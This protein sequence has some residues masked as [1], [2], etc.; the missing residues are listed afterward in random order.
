MHLITVS[1]KI[2]IKKRVK[3]ATTEFLREFDKKWCSTYPP[4]VVKRYNL[5][6]YE[7]IPYLEIENKNNNFVEVFIEENATGEDLK[8]KIQTLASVS[9]LR[10]PEAYSWLDPDS[11]DL[12]SMDL[13]LNEDMMITDVGISTIVSIA[14]KKYD[15]VTQKYLETFEIPRKSKIYNQKYKSEPPLP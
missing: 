13:K 1:N 3:L 15:E 11:F 14:F 8:Y 2:F 5:D 10:I 6:V 9:K 7:E 4:E 12:F